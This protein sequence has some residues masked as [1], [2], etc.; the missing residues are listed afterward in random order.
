LPAA[1]RGLRG[2]RKGSGLIKRS[3]KALRA[4]R[5]INA[6]ATVATRSVSRLIGREFESAIKH[7]PRTGPVRA[8]LPNGEVIRLWSRGDDWVSNQVFWRGWNGYEPETTPLFFRLARDANLVLDVGAYVGFFAILAG[9]ANRRSRV[10]AFEPM[11]ASGER[12]RRHLELNRLDNV[13]L[14]SAA[15]FAVAGEGELFHSG[16]LP[17][18][19]SLVRGWASSHPGL[20]SSI[21]Q[22]VAIDSF[23]EERGLG[24]VS[25]LK[26]DIETGEPDALRGMRRT[27]ERDR[28][29]IVC[30]V[31]STA[32]AAELQRLLAPFGYRFHHLTDS[33]PLES[34]QIE[35]HP[36]WLNWLFT[37]MPRERLHALAYE[38]RSEA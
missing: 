23:L 3:L 4:W 9:L 13:E 36:Q 16:H 28:P 19:T 38:A 1:T 25:L 34:P 26:L 8:T 29:T 20:R 21:V 24:S 31:L 2:A 7:L 12:L 6:P 35:P 15:V 5:P 11:P 18:S 37:V 33:G 14:V 22:T 30:E 27:L 17:T 10:F 32:V